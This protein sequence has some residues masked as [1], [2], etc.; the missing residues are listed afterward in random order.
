MVT[1]GRTFAWKV[2]DGSPN[3]I[4]P[5]RM[6]HVVQL[7]CEMAEC[8]IQG[9]ACSETSCGARHRVAGSSGSGGATGVV[10]L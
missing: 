9:F 10:H 2:E 7:F 4:L 5:S 8:L 6:R 3:R 1:T